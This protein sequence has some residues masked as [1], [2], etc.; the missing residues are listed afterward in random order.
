MNIYI[1]I[2]FTYTHAQLCLLAAY[3]SLD[4]PGSSYFAWPWIFT[5][6]Q[7]RFQECVTGRNATKKWLLKTWHCLQEIKRNHFLEMHSLSGVYTVRKAPHEWPDM[8]ALLDNNFRNM[9]ARDAERQGV[10][11]ARKE[12]TQQ[13]GWIFVWSFPMKAS[14]QQNSCTSWKSTLQE[15]FGRIAYCIPIL[16]FESCIYD[17]SMTQTPEMKQQARSGG[18][19]GGSNGAI[20]SQAL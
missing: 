14:K 7:I 6:I 2:W 13:I 8:A 4:V 5:A 20:S 12:T 9:L 16:A 10:E 15:Y 19:V 17:V 3:D 11:A 1:Y 18:A